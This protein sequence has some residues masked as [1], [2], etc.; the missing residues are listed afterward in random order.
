MDVCVAKSIQKINDSVC[1][2]YRMLLLE[3]VAKQL[4]CECSYKHLAKIQFED[5]AMKCINIKQGRGI[6][7]DFSLGT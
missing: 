6:R 7:G 4:Q 2:I 1:A 5:E 3:R